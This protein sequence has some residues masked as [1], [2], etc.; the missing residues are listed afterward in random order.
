[1]TCCR[2]EGE[3]NHTGECNLCLDHDLER[4]EEEEEEAA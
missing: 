1:M 2:C 3:C 4:D